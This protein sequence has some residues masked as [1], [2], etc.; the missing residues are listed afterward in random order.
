M[1]DYWG[2]VWGIERLAEAADQ[3]GQSARAARLWS[4]AD[5][6]RQIAGVLWHPGFHS[7]YTEQR[8]VSLRAKL[9]ETQWGQ[10][11]KEGQAL[12]VDK[13]VAVALGV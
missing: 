11:W 9:G 6:L 12:T 3:F 13:A 1:K 2:L 8:F 7:Y 10:L 5:A 4:A